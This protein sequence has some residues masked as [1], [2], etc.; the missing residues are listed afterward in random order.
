MHRHVNTL[1]ARPAG[2]VPSRA[3]RPVA[4]DITCAKTDADGLEGPDDPREAEHATADRE[5]DI[6]RGRCDLD[7]IP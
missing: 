1:A 7:A 2:P 6:G 3:R 5:A 4:G